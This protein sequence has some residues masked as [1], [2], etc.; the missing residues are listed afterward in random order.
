MTHP[1]KGFIVPLLLILIAL[2]LAG[3]G[4][5]AYMNWDVPAAQT[6]ATQA[7]SSAQTSEIAGWRKFTDEVIGIEFQYPGT[8]DVPRMVGEYGS[9]MNPYTVAMGIFN[10]YVSTTTPAVPETAK[11]EEVA[12]GGIHGIK[13]SFPD[14]PGMFK[15]AQSIIIQLSNRVV[16]I[17]YDDSGSDA[18]NQIYEQIIKSIAFT[19]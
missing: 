11:K 2:F 7:T 18:V 15:G 13:V 12:V 5:Y 3:G 19:R 14:E 16:V 4:T 17:N 6:T 8:W 9:S 1:Q 10:I